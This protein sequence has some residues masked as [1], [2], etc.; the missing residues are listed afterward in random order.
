MECPA[1]DGDSHSMM[2]PGLFARL[3]RAGNFVSRPPLQLLPYQGTTHVSGPRS[4][5][6]RFGGCS[7]FARRI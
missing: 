6:S 1:D 2:R 3:V 4:K 5:P 7:S